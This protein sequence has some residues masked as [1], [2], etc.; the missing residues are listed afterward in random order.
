VGN[1]TCDCGGPIFPVIHE[2]DDYQCQLC[3]MYYTHRGLRRVLLIRRFGLAIGSR[4]P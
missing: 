2:W 3:G 1:F 4:I